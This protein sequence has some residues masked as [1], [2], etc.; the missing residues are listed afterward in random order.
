MG[1]HHSFFTPEARQDLLSRPIRECLLLNKPLLR[2]D[3]QDSI[4]DVLK[5]F[6]R[7]HL[8]SSP[9]CTSNWEYGAAFLCNCYQTIGASE[10]ISQSSM[11]MDVTCSQ[12]ADFSGCNPTLSVPLSSP[13]EEVVR[14]MM[15]SQTHRMVLVDDTTVTPEMSGEIRHLV[16]QSGLVE[17][18][19]LNLDRLHP[20]PDATLKELG[21]FGTS[22]VVCCEESAMVID[23][24]ATMNRV[25]ITALPAQNASGTVTGILT[26]RDIRMLTKD[27]LSDLLMPVKDFLK[28]YRPSYILGNLQM[29][30]RDLIRSI[31]INAFHHLFFIRESSGLPTHVITL[32]DILDFVVVNP[33]RKGSLTSV[34]SVMQGRPPSTH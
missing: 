12:I 19:L 30:L 14:R 32:T 33:G 34:G 28:K 6:K 22:P 13:V 15:V 17:F 1:A 8:S 18:I 24:F 5:K 25:R 16:T 20:T 11:M 7:N 3:P 2:L 9:I 26:I 4:L 21:F 23:V 10:F 27:T 29:T 31:S